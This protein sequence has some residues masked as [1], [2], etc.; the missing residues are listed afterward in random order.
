[1]FGRERPSQTSDPNVWFKGLPAQSFPNG[2]VTLQASFVTPFIVNDVDRSPWIWALEVLAAYDAVAR[3]KE[4]AHGQS[5]VP[6]GWAPGT[7]VG[8]FAAKYRSPLLLNGLLR[9]FKVG[10]RAQF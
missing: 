6:A 8:Y 4:G 7:S 10:L 2:E 1:V 9:G 3:V 5:N